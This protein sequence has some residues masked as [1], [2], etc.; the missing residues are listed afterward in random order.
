MASVPS[1]REHEQ[2]FTQST[3]ILLFAKRRL[4]GEGN[5]L[6]NYASDETT[7]LVVCSG[8]FI[9]WCRKLGLVF[10]RP[11]SLTTDW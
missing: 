6:Q 4:V 7:V 9:V 8:S 3:T 10:E 11:P 5:K 1:R 2:E